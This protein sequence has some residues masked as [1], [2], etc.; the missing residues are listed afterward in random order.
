VQ[1]WAEM[2]VLGNKE[3][4]SV[5]DL[6][7]RL[8]SPKT[9]KSGA[10]YRVMTEPRSGD[11]VLHLVA[12]VEKGARRGAFS[13]VFPVLRRCAKRSRKSRLVQGNGPAAAPTIGLTWRAIGSSRRSRECKKSRRGCLI[14]Y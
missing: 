5:W 7:R 2:T 11:P 10:E 3:P 4:G 9:N 6:G 13:M 1:Y 14:S 8:W 12:G